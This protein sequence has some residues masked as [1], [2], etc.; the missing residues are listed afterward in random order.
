MPDSQQ[1]AKQTVNDPSNPCPSVGWTIFWF[2]VFYPVVFWQGYKA[3]RYR[4]HCPDGEAD[5]NSIIILTLAIVAAAL[6]LAS[7]IL[8]GVVVSDITAAPQAS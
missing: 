2:I 4:V 6:L 7:L 8:I 3:Y 5:G 1:P